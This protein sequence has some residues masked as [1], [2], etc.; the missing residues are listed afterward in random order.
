MKNLFAII[1]TTFALSNYSLADV[2]VKWLGGPTL[3]IKFDDVTIITDPILGEGDKA[4]F[5][6]DPNEPFDLNKGPNMKFHK[7][8]TSVPKFD[9]S[10]VDYVLL[11]HGHEDHLDQKALKTFNKTKFIGAPNDSSKKLE[12]F[13]ILDWGQSLKLHTKNNGRIEIKAVP[14][15]HSLNPSINKIL[16][17]GNSYFIKF[18]KEDKSYGVY[19]SGDSFYR[20]EIKMA[21]KKDKIDLFI[22]HL[23]KVGMKGPLGQISMSNKD[24]IAMAKS[25]KI[26]RVLPI[27]H[28]TLELYQEKIDSI[29]EHA[30]NT[31]LLLD[32]IAEGST[33]FLE[34]D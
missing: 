27:H 5:M 22:P 9:K 20:D 1:L 28:S 14:A 18:I 7:R 12:L 4:Y 32:L 6:G 29:V 11:S 15:Y 23:G 2:Q 33:L 30:R 26:K 10:D 24:A 8:H 25:L 17:K 16:G 31:N 21:L 13:S 3:L 19:W 34:L